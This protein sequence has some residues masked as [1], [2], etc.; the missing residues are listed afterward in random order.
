[1]RG[2]ERALA[3]GLGPAIRPF[4]VASRGLFDDVV[5]RHVVMDA[6]VRRAVA[7]GARRLIIL[8]A[9]YDT[10]AWRFAQPGLDVFELDFPAT[11]ARKERCI[12]HHRGRF[13]EVSVT[14]VGVDF[15][16]SAWPEALPR[17]SA[18][19]LVVWEGVS[20]YLEAEDVVRT[21]R[22]VAARLPGAAVVMDVY[23]G[24]GD[25]L[26]RLGGRVLGVLGEPLRFGLPAQEQKPFFD[27]AGF[28]VER[29]HDLGAAPTRIARAGSHLDVLELR[30][31]P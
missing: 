29:A 20:M 11:L 3:R 6:A 31:V 7:E 16:S 26:A 23:A 30:P 1:L 5:E 15:T 24:A 22:A 27:A 18:P 9:G 8:G 12:R 2:P 28:R 4:A 13:P 25:A 21:L 14:R 19:A 10:R 17:T